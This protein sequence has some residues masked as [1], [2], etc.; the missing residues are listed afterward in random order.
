MV[1]GANWV[2][3]GQLISRQAWH[4]VEVCVYSGRFCCPRNQ[5]RAKLCCV[6]AHG[7]REA[8]TQ[9]VAHLRGS[10]VLLSCLLCLET[11]C[12]FLPEVFG[13]S[14]WG[15]ALLKPPSI[16]GVET[17]LP[18]QVYL[19]FLLKP[20]PNN[21]VFGDSL[22]VRLLCSKISCPHAEVPAENRA[23]IKTS[24]MNVCR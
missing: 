23:A 9:A 3:G 24:Q 17:L 15:K 7:K 14:A 19:S 12:F 6:T 16:W 4:E 18:W 13:A 1:T 11:G 10:V 8:C 22:R 5:T 21:L 20:K 2:T